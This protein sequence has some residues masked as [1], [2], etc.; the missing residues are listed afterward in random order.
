MFILILI[1]IIAL[2][3]WYAAKQRKLKQHF[4]EIMPKDTQRFT[5]V[6]PAGE[7]F[8]Q[9]L[10]TDPEHRVHFIAINDKKQVS[11]PESGLPEK[12]FYIINISFMPNITETIH[13]KGHAGSALAGGLI[14]GGVGAVIGA[15]RKKDSKIERTEHK[16][17]TYLTLVDVNLKETYAL[18]LFMDTP[19]FN[20]LNNLYTLS[21]FELQNLQ[22]ELGE[23]EDDVKNVDNQSEPIEQRLE[24][25]K[26]LLDKEL[27]TSEDYEN[28]KKQILGL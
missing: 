22:K 5:R 4:K 25:L 14:A 21:D 10:H 9:V 23:I 1:I 2:I 16:A 28:K 26:A 11:F 6:V 19:K 8:S 18:Q 20:E 7:E 12:L 27:I 3:W 13:T 24:R 17:L 15:S